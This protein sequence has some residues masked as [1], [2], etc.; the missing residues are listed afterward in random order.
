MTFTVNRRHKKLFFCF[1]GFALFSILFLGS[2]TI[3]GPLNFRNFMAIVV[4]L[5]SL[6]YPNYYSPKNKAISIYYLWLGV[7]FIIN[8]ISGNISNSSFIQ[9]LLTYHL[10]CLFTIFIIPRLVADYYSLMTVYRW[11]SLFYVANALFTILQFHNVP[12]AWAISTIISPMSE[13][14]NELFDDLSR[15]GD[16]FLGRSITP[17]LKGFVVTNGYFLTFLL[18]FVTKGFWETDRRKLIVSSLVLCIGF[19]AIYCTQQRM[20]FYLAVAYVAYIIITK[21]KGR[22]KI[23]ILISGLLFLCLNTGNNFDPEKM[24]RLL[25]V[26]DNIRSHT[27]ENLELFMSDPSNVL[28]GM[29][30][31]GAGSKSELVLLT[32]CHNAFLDSIRRGGI[33]SL[34]VMALLYINMFYQCGRILIKSRFHSSMTSSLALSCCIFL[35]YSFTHSTGLQSGSVEYWLLYMLMLSSIHVEKNVQFKSY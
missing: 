23:V 2:W 32:M 9:G 34:I 26:E 33:I 12:Q 1:T 21:T 35:L 8:L 16:G 10:L 4:F 17:G 5:I 31:G 11:I 22:T 24:G 3:Y 27:W 20:A 15:I 18:P 28:L 6:L 14:G 19:Y 30:E 7:Y 29:H 13:I 25:S